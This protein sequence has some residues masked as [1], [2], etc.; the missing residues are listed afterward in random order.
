MPS[1]EK[2]STGVEGVSVAVATV[3]E[4]EVR[5]GSSAGARSARHR[6]TCSRCGGAET[7][8]RRGDK[9]DLRGRHGCDLAADGVRACDRSRRWHVARIGRR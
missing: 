3:P 7:R 9:G 1:A 6:A 2:R 4:M 8:R 5:T